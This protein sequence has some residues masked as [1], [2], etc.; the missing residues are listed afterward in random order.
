MPNKKRSVVVGGLVFGVMA[1]VY[2]LTRA[3]SVTFIDSGE[4]ATVATVVGIAHPTGYP[5]F[6]LLGRLVA[7]V[8]LGGEEI[9]RLN[10]F[11]SLLTALAAAA[12]YGLVLIVAQPARAS[13]RSSEASGDPSLAQLA[14]AAAGALVFGTSVTVWAQSVAVEVYALH[15]L[16]I[17]ILIP[18][19]LA[20]L[21]A[22]VRDEQSIGRMLM[23]AAFVLGLS[24]SNH[25]TTVLVLPAFVYL[26][27]STLSLTKASL[28]RLV[29]IAPFFLLGLTPYIYLLVRSSSNP[30]QDW[31]HPA[32]VGRFFAHVSGAQYRSWI[33]SG[34]E[35][36][37][38][39]FKYFVGRL[40]EEFSWIALLLAAAG[41]LYF[42]KNN[43]RLF[44]FLVILFVS[45]VGYAINY[46]I[47]DIDSYFLLAFFVLGLAAA[48]GMMELGVRVAGRLPRLLRPAVPLAC[49][50][51]AVL[52]FVAHRDSVDQSDNF[53][54]EDY[55][56]TI[57]RA[58]DSNAVVLSYQWDYFVSPSLYFQRVRHERADVAVIDKELLRRSW[59]FTSLER[60]WPWL[61]AR[62][63]ESIDRFLVQLRKFE[64]G[65]PYR[66]EEIEAS[67]NAMINDLIRSSRIDRPVYVG[68]E[69][70]PQFGQGLERVPAGLLFK[71]EEPGRDWGALAHGQMRLRRTRY[72]DKLVD[73]LGYQCAKMLVFRALWAGR[74]AR[75]GEALQALEE[76]RQYSPSM[77]E[78]QILKAQIEAGQRAAGERR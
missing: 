18:V 11:A 49:A 62:S 19:Y 76:A 13:R 46:D 29:R 69:I 41:L 1:I 39:Q 7:V 15:L 78:I 31:G 33:F 66:A 56:K 12:F 5:L 71:L 35:S 37:S 65:L 30:V 52:Q 2:Q 6:T 61:V 57:L 54:V 44:W 77:P 20:G 8:P 70:E 51:V 9:V 72:K 53:L 34:F 24:F 27:I 26:Y 43:R 63:R 23:L 74:Q 32:T 3:P 75:Y 14:I 4:L 59:Y 38:R 48:H 36:A 28:M 50:A 64:G 58:V 67:Y 55:T 16:L 42:W 22:Q 45:C 17:A 40:P 68:P 60:N 47:H 21:R 73:G 10:V 25:L